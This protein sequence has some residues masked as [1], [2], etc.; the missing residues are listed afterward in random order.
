MARPRAAA[1]RGGS[2]ESFRVDASEFKAL[3]ARLKDADKKVARQLRKVLKA[4]ADDAVKAVQESALSAAPGKVVTRS[5]LGRK[6]KVSTRTR[7]RGMRKAL[8]RATTA[9]LTKTNLTV[10]TSQ[11]RMPDGMGPMV[12]AWNSR[13]FRHPVFADAVNDVRDNRTRGFRALAAARRAAGREGPGS[14]KWVNQNGSVYFTEGMRESRDT[15]PRNLKE[16]MER[17]ARELM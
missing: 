15:I 11:R 4:A 16:A 14:W 6:R 17:V 1:R 8:A 13:R 2:G 7:S 3:N 5:R 9:S 10:R 12:K